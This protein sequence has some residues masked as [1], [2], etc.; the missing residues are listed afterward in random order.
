[1]CFIQLPKVVLQL[2]RDGLND[3]DKIEYTT[4][5]QSDCATN[6]FSMSNLNRDIGHK[7]MYTSNNHTILQV[8]EMGQSELQKETVIDAGWLRLYFSPIFTSQLNRADQSI[9]VQLAQVSDKHR[10]CK[11]TLLYWLNFLL[12][13]HLLLVYK[14]KA[15]KTHN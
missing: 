15:S 3:I 11:P 13:V 7:K 1:M 5:R 8:R 10:K 4:K 9:S 6:R 14:G 2:H 12:K